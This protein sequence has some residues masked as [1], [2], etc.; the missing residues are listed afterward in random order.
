MKC[1]F[2]KKSVFCMICDF[3]KFGGLTIFC[4][5]IIFVSI[6]R[7]RFAAP[8]TLIIITRHGNT[9]IRVPQPVSISTFFTHLYQTLTKIHRT[10][11]VERQIPRDF[12]LESENTG[13]SCSFPLDII[14]AEQWLLKFELLYRT[15][16]D[17]EIT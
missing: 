15:K 8:I 17:R 9:F 6:S 3:Y 4:I 13:L 7:R 12:P 2:A 1:V 14:C 5:S 16:S 10:S 11:T